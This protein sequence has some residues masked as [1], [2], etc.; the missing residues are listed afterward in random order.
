MKPQMHF[1]ILTLILLTWIIWWAPNNASSWQLGLNS[2]FKGLMEFNYIHN[3]HQ[4][5]AGVAQS[6]TTA[7]R[8]GLHGPWIES[9]WGAR[10]SAP[11]QAGPGA[12]PASCKMGTVSQS[13]GK[14][15]LE[16]RLKKEYSYTSTPLSGP[17]WPVLGWTL[18]CT[19]IITDMFRPLMWPSSGSW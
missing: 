6:V 4:Q 17:S 7:T 18:A 19:V 14:P 12:H 13:R 8:Y 1:D 3:N 9:L 15:H 2:A 11:I 10:F 16:P 5:W